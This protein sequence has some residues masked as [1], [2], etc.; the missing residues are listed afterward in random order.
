MADEIKM[1]VAQ[2]LQALKA[3]SKVA[4]RATAEIANDVTDPG[5]KAAL[6]TGNKVSQ[7]WA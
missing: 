5:L 4:K 7:G 1:L 3:G 2:G 6:E